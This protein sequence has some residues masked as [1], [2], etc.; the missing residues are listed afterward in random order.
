MLIRF[1]KNIFRF[2]YFLLSFDDTKGINENF[3]SVIS[4][5]LYNSMISINK[6]PS[7]KIEEVGKSKAELTEYILQLMNLLEAVCDKSYF[8]EM[9]DS[10]YLRAN[11]L[12]KEASDVFFE[13]V[14]ELLLTMHEIE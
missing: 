9:C 5:F 13:M 4:D 14:S 8:L 6:I 1:I 3:R 10:D 7:N 12:R 11:R 2:K